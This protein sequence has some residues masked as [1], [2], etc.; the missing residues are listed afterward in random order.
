[1]AFTFKVDNPDSFGSIGDL[2]YVEGSFNNTEGSTGGTVKTNL[3][4]VH[5]VWVTPTGSTIHFSVPTFNNTFPTVN[6]DFI[7]ATNGD[8]PGRFIALGR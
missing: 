1:M 6:G 4:S 3:N 5:D 7:V 8:R 2:R